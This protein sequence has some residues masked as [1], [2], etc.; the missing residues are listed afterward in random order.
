LRCQHEERVSSH[1]P[2]SGA[3]EAMGEY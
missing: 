2:A 3:E 1:Q